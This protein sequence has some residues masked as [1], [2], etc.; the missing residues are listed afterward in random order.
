MNPVVKKALIGTAVVIISAAVIM[1]VISLMH[2]ARN[3]DLD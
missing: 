3:H 1:L 2:R